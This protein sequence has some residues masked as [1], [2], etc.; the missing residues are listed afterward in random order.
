MPAKVANLKQHKQLS[1]EICELGARLYDAIAREPELR[2]VRTQALEFLDGM[3]G[4]S[5][6]N[7]QAYIESCIKTIMQQQEENTREM[8]KYVSN[9]EHE[10]KQLEEKLKKKSAELERSEKRY[11]NLVTVKPAF[12][13]EYERLEQ[14]LASLQETYVNKYRNLDYLEN[15]LEAFNKIEEEK[16]KKAQKELKKIREKQKADEIKAFRGDEELDNQ[17]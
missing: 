16:L 15:E 10:Q 1:N 9:M 5:D 13:E 14:E 12:M 3:N 4:V 8:T 11:R 17:I 6:G 2:K 7:D